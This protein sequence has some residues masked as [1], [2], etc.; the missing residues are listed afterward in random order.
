LLYWLP[1]DD[2]GGDDD[3]DEDSAVT[4]FSYKTIFSLFNFFLLVPFLLS[5]FY[6]LTFVTSGLINMY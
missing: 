6:F 2:V 1:A 5:F 3:D 4:S